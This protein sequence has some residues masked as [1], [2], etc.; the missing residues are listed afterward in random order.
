MKKMTPQEARQL[1]P[2]V[3]AYI[4]DGIYELL[5]RRRMIEH[6][7]AL[8][9]TL[10]LETVAVVRASAQSAAYEDIKDLLTE[11]EEAIFKR[12][13]NANG[14]QVPRNGNPTEYRRATGL[15]ALFGYLY[16][17]GDAERI[18]QLYGVIMEKETA[19]G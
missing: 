6:T 2:L 5:T 3:L 16:L 19:N 18:E 17:I 8:V 4:G 1:N 10:H 13:R 9:G 12:G 11:E 7:G 15:E 14:N